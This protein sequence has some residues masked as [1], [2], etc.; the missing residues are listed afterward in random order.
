MR[1]GEYIVEYRR[2]HG[3]SQRQF[4]EK[5]GVTNGY[6]SMIEANANPATGKPIVPSIDK[7]RTIAN[8]MNI[9]LDKL[10]AALDDMP[11]SLQGDIKP[12]SSQKLVPILGTVRC[13]SNGLAVE[14]P[15][16]YEPA[17]VENPD[18]Y[19]YLRADG[20]SMEPYIYEGDYVL[21]HKQDDVDSG[22]LAIV[23]VGG[24]EGTLKKVLKQANTVILQPFNARYPARIFVGR[25]CASIRIVGRVMKT[26]HNW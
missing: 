14:E 13:G 4:A 10:V 1:L 23:I 21:V 19:F 2:K 9:S 12:Y 16:G 20:D 6:V 26:T 3:L 11:V 17:D 18:E 8:G 25:E 22:E 15:E 24:E 7:L 5:C